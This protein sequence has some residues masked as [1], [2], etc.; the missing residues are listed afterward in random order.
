[1]K[2]IWKK[3]NEYYEV[4]NLGN[5]RNAINGRI[6]RQRIDKKHGYCY[7]TLGYGDKIVSASVHRMVAKV[8]IPNPDELREVDHIDCNKQNNRVDNLRWVSSSTNKLYAIDNHLYDNN[9]KHWFGERAPIIA[10]DLTTGEELE[11]ISINQAERA[12]GTKHI[13]DVLKGKRNQAK[14]YTFRY[15]G[16]D[17]YA[18]H[19]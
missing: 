7:V 2:E 11:F 6:K 14:G 10:T 19:R 12:L 18:N 13:T 15:K 8:F 1:M 5:V 4:S 17:A 9:K 3:Y 16:G